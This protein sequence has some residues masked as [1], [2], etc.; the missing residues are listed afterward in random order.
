MKRVVVLSAAIGAVLALGASQGFSQVQ[1]S[2]SGKL[3]VTAKSSEARAAF[4]DAWF[5]WANV[6]A[7]RADSL[8][9]AALELDPE[10]G[11]ARAV[12][13]A[14]APGLNQG[15][16]E[17]ELN[18]AVAD[19]ARGSTNELLVAA[20]IRAIVLTR[21]AEAAALS[22]AASAL[23]PNDADVAFLRAVRNGF[24]VATTEDLIG[25]TRKFP[26]YAA[27]YNLI[28]YRRYAEGNPSAALLMAETYMKLAPNHPNSHDTYAE[29]LQFNGRLPEAMQHYQRA[30]E[31][32]PGYNAGEA[33]LAE[34]HML[35]GH[36]AV[37]RD[38]YAKAAS[39]ARTPTTRL[40]S[41]ASGAAIYVLE[42][43]HKDA[44]REL[45]VIAATAEREQLPLLAA[46]YHRWAALI[47]AS[48]GDPKMVA[49]HLAK[50]AEL[51]GT[52][53][54]ATQ[55]RFTALALA[56]SGQ[57]D[58]ARVAA[59]QYDRA[60]ATGTAAQRATVREVY[61]VLAVAQRDLVRA[62]TELDQAGAAPFGKAILAQAL[63]KAGSKDDAQAI[64]TAIQSSG[65]ATAFDVLARAKVA[66]L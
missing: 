7:T 65:T 39:H 26:E 52:P 31:I 23:M 29:I 20:L 32:D 40:N 54:P 50:A 3:E 51:G 63:K 10:F 24:G 30:L 27:A 2:A 43:K 45:G 5:N 61:G 11:L 17:V 28:A 33:G 46:G 16:R 12:G 22:D 15:Q 53:V 47:E 59:S 18:R 57:I 60:L 62:K 55:H 8:S 6:N 37:A 19:A 66:K 9:K 42:G 21:N 25:V 4:A 1:Q 34:V 36:P 56:L 13:A 48:F 41:L 35:M 14:V 38:A 49:P 64:K 58:S 44:V